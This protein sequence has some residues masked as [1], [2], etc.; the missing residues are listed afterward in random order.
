MRLKKE[1]ITFLKDSFKTIIKTGKLYL[2]GSRI[3]DSKKGGDIDLLIVSN[4]ANKKDIRKFR[5][6]FFKKFGEQKLDIV[7]DDGSFKNPFIKHILKKAV[8]L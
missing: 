5:I 4:T 2:F 6:E 3:D 1:E 7:L 8:L